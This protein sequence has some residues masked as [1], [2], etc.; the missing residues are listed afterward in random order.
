MLFVHSYFM[1]F[2]LVY[3]GFLNTNIPSF[4]SLRNDFRQLSVDLR[5]QMV[6]HDLALIH[7][8]LHMVDLPTKAPLLL[9]LPLPGY[10]L[11]H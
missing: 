5:S 9:N 8:M 2:I 4:F 7:V 10:R 1:C 6:G 11:K 3:I